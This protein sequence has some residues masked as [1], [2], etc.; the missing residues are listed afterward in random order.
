MATNYI[1]VIDNNNQLKSLLPVLT[2][3]GYRINH[4]GDLSEALSLIAEEKPDLILM[5]VIDTD[6]YDAYFELKSHS[7]IIDIALIFIG[8]IPQESDKLRFLED[9]GIDCIIK[10]FHKSEIIIR[11]NNQLKIAHNQKIL[12]AEIELRLNAEEKL[13]K[14]NLTIEKEIKDKENANNELKN[15]KLNILQLEKMAAL[16]TLVTGIAHEINNPINFVYGLSHNLKSNFE[17]LKKFIFQLAGD[18]IDQK[19]IE[20]FDNHFQ[21]ISNNL[22]DINDGSERIKIIV[23]NLRTFSRLDE[24]EIK[25]VDITEGINSTLRLIQS[26]YKNIEFICDFQEKRAINC[27][28]S[29]LNQVFMNIMINACQAIQEKDKTENCDKLGKLYIKTFLKDNKDDNLVIE[30]SDNGIGMTKEVKNRIFE[31]FFTTKDVGNGT[32]MGMSISY[33]IIQKHNGFINIDSELGKGTTF[34]ITLPFA[35]LKL[36]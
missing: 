2:A 21:K 10:P 30:F 17:D 24:G 31:P 14:A 22:N 33:D 3:H 5:N 36:S 6:I 26:K 12:D 1:L 20:M 8:E 15:I 32:G 9:K 25:N 23:Q 4:S 13:I 11:I 27:Y 29:Q 18:D 34:S 35:F 7:F 28:P 19:F 16:G